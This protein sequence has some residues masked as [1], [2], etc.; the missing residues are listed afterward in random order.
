M[1][2]GYCSFSVMSDPKEGGGLIVYVYM[3]FVFNFVLGVGHQVNFF[4]SH[5]FC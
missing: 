2:I 3:C 4:F 5:S 1:F